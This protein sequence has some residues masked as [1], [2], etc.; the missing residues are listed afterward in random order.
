MD[1]VIEYT[2]KVINS[3]LYNLSPEYFSIFDDN[4]HTNKELIFAIDQRQDLNTSHNRLGY[5][6]LSGSQYPLAAIP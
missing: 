2:N 6:S 1:K 4:N 5:W 3:G